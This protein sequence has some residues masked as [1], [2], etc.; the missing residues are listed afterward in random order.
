M[1]LM[2]TI[3]FLCNFCNAPIKYKIKLWAHRG[4]K[5]NWRTLKNNRKKG[6]S[7]IWVISLLCWGIKRYNYQI[8]LQTCPFSVFFPHAVCLRHPSDPPVLIIQLHQ[9]VG[10]FFHPAWM[11]K[12]R[13]VIKPVI[14]QTWKEK[15]DHCMSPSSNEQPAMSPSYE[16]TD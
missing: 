4:I 12:V 13:P 2:V 6:R 9:G 11:W 10:T 8:V 7:E 14:R 15:L 1:K 3:I 16:A 5:I